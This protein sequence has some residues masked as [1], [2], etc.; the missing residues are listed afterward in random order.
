MSDCEHGVMKLSGKM[1]LMRKVVDV[2]NPSKRFAWESVDDVVVRNS[3]FIY[4]IEGEV[5]ES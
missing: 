1:S 3:L 5:C 2:W 4:G